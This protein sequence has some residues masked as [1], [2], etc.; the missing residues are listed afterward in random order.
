MSSDPTHPPLDAETIAFAGQIFDRARSGDAEEIEALLGAGLPANMCNDKGDTLLMLASY[1]GHPATVRALLAHGAD[2]ERANDRG[3]TPLVAAAFKGDRGCVEALLEHGAAIDGH[4]GD[5]RTALM[6]AA[7]F[8]RLEMVELLLDRGADPALCDA[9]GFSAAEAA[10]KMGAG[11][12][13][14][15]LRQATGG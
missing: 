4:G 3:Q 6:T 9:A 11:E 8:N 10:D 13:A 12:A 7:M 5:G 15:R 14:A 1:H 2:P